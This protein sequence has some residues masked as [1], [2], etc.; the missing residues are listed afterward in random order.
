MT[1]SM[2]TLKVTSPVLLFPISTSSWLF[3]VQ[4]FLLLELVS[5]KMVC[6]F[7]GHVLQVISKYFL[8]LTDSA[9]GVT[10]KMFK[11]S[12][13]NLDT[14]FC[15]PRAPLSGRTMTMTMTREKGEEG[16]CGGYIRERCMGP[17][18]A[19]HM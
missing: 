4:E 7:D 19:F 9:A 14:C 3:N 16:R 12:A 18:E 2:K 8:D 15:S 13:F 11:V 17:E 10:C 5:E 6:S 1:E